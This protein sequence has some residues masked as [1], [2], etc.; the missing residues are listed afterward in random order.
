MTELVGLKPEIM[1]KRSI[2]AAASPQHGALD[3]VKDAIRSP[4]VKALLLA[5]V[6][7]LLLCVMGK[8]CVLVFGHRTGSA[9]LRWRFPW[10]GV[11]M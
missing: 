1:E 8:A 9:A 7:S 5:Q 2:L 6:L 11:L 4:L 3:Y 10:H